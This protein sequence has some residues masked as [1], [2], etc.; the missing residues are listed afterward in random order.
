MTTN[1]GGSCNTNPRDQSNDVLL[2][3]TRTIGDEKQNATVGAFV[4]AN[5]HR[6]PQMGTVGAFANVNANGHA[7]SLGINHTPKYNMTTMEAS[8][9]ANLWTSANQNTSLN[10]TASHSQHVSG[11]MTGFKSNNYML[12]LN[13]RF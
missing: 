6:G 2:N 5:D 1:I 4:A 13:H 8:A 9:T 11:P 10:A 12:N 7:A 3:L